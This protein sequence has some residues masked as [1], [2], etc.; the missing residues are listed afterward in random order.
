MEN[1]PQTEHRTDKGV[2]GP[3]VSLNWTDPQGN[4][5]GGFSTGSRFAV[6][7]QNGPV[8]RDAGEQPTGAFVKDLLVAAYARLDFYEDNPP[9]KHPQSPRPR[10][11][12]DHPG[13]PSRTAPRPQR[14]RRVRNPSGIAPSTDPKDR[15]T[16]ARLITSLALNH[17]R[18]GKSAAP[19]RCRTKMEY[20]RT[21]AGDGAICQ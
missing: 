12:P 2:A 11:T 3:V 4:P 9:L 10:G 17:S 20:R 1:H 5:A 13:R 19:R 15:D 16:R 14:T 21:T 6:A 7:R 8:N 18:A